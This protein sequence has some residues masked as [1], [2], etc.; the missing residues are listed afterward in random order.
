MTPSCENRR[1]VEASSQRCQNMPREGTTWQYWLGSRG[2]RVC[3]RAGGDLRTRLAS[4]RRNFCRGEGGRERE[5]L[6]WQPLSSLSL[7]EGTEGQG[8]KGRRHRAG[9]PCAT[10][11]DQLQ[12]QRTNH[13]SQTAAPPGWWSTVATSIEV[14][15]G[16]RSAFKVG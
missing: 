10:L 13:P 6:F 11:S 12:L 8:S 4:N 7:Y 3:L 15:R 1:L 16:N 2:S 14:G 9:E 5:R